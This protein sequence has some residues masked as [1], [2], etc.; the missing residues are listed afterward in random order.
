LG[1]KQ[2]IYNKT[3]KNISDV[4]GK[5]LAHKKPKVKTSTGRSRFT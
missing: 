2:D 5:I 1:E 3:N 4:F